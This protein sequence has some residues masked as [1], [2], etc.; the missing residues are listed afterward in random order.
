MGLLK[1]VP[2]SGPTDAGIIYEHLRKASS[3]RTQG[4]RMFTD[5]EIARNSA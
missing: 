4:R 2:I 1:Q 5:A 3:M